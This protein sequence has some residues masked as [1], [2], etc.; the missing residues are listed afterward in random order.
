M[1]G[2]RD[3]QACN[4]DWITP[5]QMRGGALYEGRLAGTKRGVAGELVELSELG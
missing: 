1:L 5:P 4:V 2:M 3:L